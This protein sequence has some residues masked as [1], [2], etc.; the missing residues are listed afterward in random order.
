[1]A[2][3]KSF[4][5]NKTYRTMIVLIVTT[6]ILLI[7]LAVGLVI[8]GERSLRPLQKDTEALY[9]AEKYLISLVKK[10][11]DSEP[12]AQTPT[13]ESKVASENA[14]LL[15]AAENLSQHVTRNLQDMETA[16][17]TSLSLTHTAAGGLVVLATMLGMMTLLFQRR[18]LK[19][20]QA[21]SGLLRRLAVRDYSPT[22]LDGID[23]MLHPIFASYNTLVNRLDH[24]QQAHEVRHEEMQRQV[25]LAVGALIAQR[26][27]L[28]RTERLAAVGEMAA[29]MA[30]E[31]RNPLASIRAACGSLLDDAVDSDT[32]ERLELVLHEIDRLID[33]VANQLDHARHKPEPSKR[34]DVV[35]LIKDLADLVSYQLP[36]NLDLE[37]KLDP[38]TPIVQ[39]LPPNG[40]RRSLLNLILNA[41]KALEPDPGT[42]RISA[43][44]TGTELRIVVADNG[45]GFPLEFLQQGARRFRSTHGD[46]TGLGLS[47]VRRYAEELGGRFVLEN[48][49]SGG[50]RVI[51]TIPRSANTIEVE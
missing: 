1:M 48:G 45:P 33:L 29:V 9:E 16:Q 24:L 38:T 21:L 22:A 20:I 7:A 39:T 15:E 30:H 44:S 12:A 25:K 37:L 10:N 26:A 27:E 50:A 28:G 11:N 43:E 3:A 4:D 5:F 23:S 17:S 8:E 19:P 36:D 31:I 18:V 13:T 51:L 34:T 42:I 49:E 6:L 14:M 2:A 32:R 47:M 35:Q 41:K 40:L 46:G